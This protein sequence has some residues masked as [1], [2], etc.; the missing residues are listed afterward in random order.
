MNEQVMGSTPPTIASQPQAQAKGFI[1][2]NTQGMDFKSLPPGTVLKILSSTST[3]QG[4]TQITTNLGKFTLPAHITLTDATALKVIGQGLNKLLQPIILQ[5]PQKN[6][7]RFSAATI[8]D[9][10]KSPDAQAMKQALGMLSGGARINL[11]TISAPKLDA[12]FK[13]EIVR[14]FLLIQS[15]QLNKSVQPK[16]LQKMLSQLSSLSRTTIDT[17]GLEWQA[18]T[19]PLRG[20]VMSPLLF[21]YRTQHNAEESESSDNKQTSHFKMQLALSQMGD[22]NLHGLLQHGKEL[23]L[24]IQTQATLSQQQIADLQTSFQQSLL[25]NGIEG[26][27][28]FERSE[29][30]S[31]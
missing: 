4:Q 16:S 3:P 24:R 1:P 11:V 12:G 9:L 23:L 13:A 19:I 2:Q 31:V 27:L 30:F 7:A 18:L 17:Q 8:S 5:T 21:W 10:P 25:L 29:E 15:A 22:I 6:S 14:L 28:T 26:K 20:E